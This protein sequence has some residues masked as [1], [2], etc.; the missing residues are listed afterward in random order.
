MD[1]QTE[2]FAIAIPCSVSHR[3]VKVLDIDIIPYNLNQFLWMFQQQLW[4]LSEWSD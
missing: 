2:D 1:R 4:S 3:V